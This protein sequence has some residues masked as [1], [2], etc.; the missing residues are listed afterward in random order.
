MT[1]NQN[2]SLVKKIYGYFETGNITG[3]I[4]MLSEDILWI[5]P[6]IKNYPPAKTHKGKK[7]VLDFFKSLGD[8]VETV[9]FEPGIFAANGDCVFVKGYYK[10][11]AK[12]SGNM[13]SSD[14]INLFTF[15]SGKIKQF[16]EFTDTAAFQNA[17]S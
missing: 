12:S 1:D 16:E 7:E 5:I 4:D 14:W 8:Y 9:S 10:F 15:D 17:F 11:K 6:P 2:I 13:I 3:V